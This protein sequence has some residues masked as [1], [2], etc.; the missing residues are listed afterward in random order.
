MTFQEYVEN[1]V[2]TGSL[3][4]SLTENLPAT[5]QR[6]LRLLNNPAVKKDVGS[7]NYDT[8]IYTISYP[9][10]LAEKTGTLAQNLVIPELNGETAIFITKHVTMKQPI[11][12]CDRVVY[13]NVIIE[14]VLNSH[15][16]Y[17]QITQCIA[18]QVVREYELTA[19]GILKAMYGPGGVLYKSHTVETNK[20]IDYKTI[21][22]AKARLG[23]NA[24]QLVVST[25]HNCIMK[26]LYE[27]GMV[28]DTLLQET[29]KTRS[30][31]IVAGLPAIETSL[32]PIIKGGQ[33]KPDKYLSFLMGANS[34]YFFV[35]QSF[36]F[37]DSSIT[38]D[39]PSGEDRILTIVTKTNFCIHVPGVKYIVGGPSID[40]DL[41]NTKNWVKVAEDKDIK[42]VALLT[43]TNE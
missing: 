40:K 37:D 27:K 24:D 18:D 9:K 13:S 19:M 34:I 39:P 5:I 10:I 2:N 4:K 43:P 32:A 15:D 36:G 1:G 30:H 11:K 28:S 42:I 25:Y 35:N 26:N 16:V 21:F 7:N 20:A 31:S 23:N 6:K 29:N 38:L 33:D 12:F 17:K 8:G 22:D 14:Y 3:A 41:S